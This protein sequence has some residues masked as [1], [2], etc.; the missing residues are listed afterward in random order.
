MKTGL[1]E[2]KREYKNVNIDQIEGAVDR[3]CPWIDTARSGIIPLISEC[4][5]L[6]WPFDSGGDERNFPHLR[7]HGVGN[8]R[9]E[10]VA[11]VIFLAPQGHVAFPRKFVQDTSVFL[12]PAWV[13]PFLSKSARLVAQ[14]VE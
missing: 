6:V 11:S 8:L 5:A 12:P 2:M 14:F 1:K 3:A 7:V 13:V 4:G 10:H 9:R